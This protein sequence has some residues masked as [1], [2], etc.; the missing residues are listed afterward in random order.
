MG[1]G[2]GGV[3]CLGALSGVFESR[4]WALPSVLSLVARF[5]LFYA[6]SVQSLLCHY[7]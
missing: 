7:I 1:L 6:H 2:M 5:C 3:R 4:S